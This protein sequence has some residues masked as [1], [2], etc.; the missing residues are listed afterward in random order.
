MSIASSDPLGATDRDHLR[1]DWLARLSALIDL[2]ERWATD[3]G[4]STKRIDKKLDD[5]AL[6]SY[7]APALL[8]Q[9]GVTRILREPSGRA[10]PGA[11]GVVDLYVLPA[12]DD[13]ATLFH[14][15]GRWLMHYPLPD[16]PIATRDQ[17]VEL[18]PFTEELLDQV[19][20]AMVPDA[21]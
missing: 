3:R 17:V 11:D 16:D 15:Q 4:W 19:L 14:Q 18:K 10:A 7:R 8:M 9:E 6:G 20:T 13:V 2:T 5:L 12:Y 1:Q 21:A